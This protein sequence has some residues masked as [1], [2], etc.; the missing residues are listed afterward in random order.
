MSRLLIFIYGLICYLLG[1]GTLTWFILFIG[2]WEFLPRHIDSDTPGPLSIALIT[3]LSILILFALQHS[4]MARLSFKQRWNKIIPRAAERSTYLLFSA[5]MMTIICLYWQPI[6]GTVWIINNTPGKIIL[7]LLYVLGWSI[8]VAASTVINHFELFG[9]QQV[10]LNFTN[11][12]EPDP[13]FSESS[14]Y[15]IIRHPIQFG[16][17]IGIWSTPIMSATHLMLSTG[18]TIYIFISLKYEEQDLVRTLGEKYRDYQKRVSMIIPF[19]K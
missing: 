8:A 1:L 2:G 4:I 9:L 7:I 19:S 3:N 5:I 14:F 15:K 17:L 13:Y 12:P 11:K 10:Y 16:T 6:D 18:L